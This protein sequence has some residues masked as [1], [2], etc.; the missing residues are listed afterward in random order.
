M[1]LCL[2]WYSDRLCCYAYATLRP[3]MTQRMQLCIYYAM[4]GTDI[5]YGARSQ[6]R[7][8]SYAPTRIPIPVLVLSYAYPHNPA[9]TAS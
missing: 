6:G 2:F 3:V 1:L 4:A 9:S 8:V 5:A 7:F